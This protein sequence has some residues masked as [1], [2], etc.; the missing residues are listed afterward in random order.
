MRI[1]LVLLLLAVP[2]SAQDIP[3]PVPDQTIRVEAPPAQVDLT[4]LVE[5]LDSTQAAALAA[6]FALAAQP[7]IELLYQ[8]IAADPVIQQ[9]EGTTE[10]VLKTVGWWVL[11][12]IAVKQLYN[13]A[14]REPDVTNIHVTHEDGDITVTVP[15][16]EHPDRKRKRDHDDDDS[17]GGG[18]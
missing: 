8:A 7:G 11:G 15:P 13:I 6:A 1:V 12:I 16:H 5:Q 17:E 9:T 18:H 10:R 14:N 2:L 3:I 4:V